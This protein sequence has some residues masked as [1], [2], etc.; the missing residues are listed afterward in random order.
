VKILPDECLPADF[1]RSFLVDS[2]LR[3]IEAIQS[4]QIVAIPA[5]G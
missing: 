1:R 3:A 5:S 4:G 2:I